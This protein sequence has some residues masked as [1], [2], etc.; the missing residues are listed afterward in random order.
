[1]HAREGEARVESALFVARAEGAES[2]R[3]E[4]GEGG[5]GLFA[6]VEF[7]GESEDFNAWVSSPDKE[8]VVAEVGITGF[9][10]GER[11]RGFA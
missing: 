5:E 6:G 2:E 1:V 8:R 11:C 10:E 4:A 9:H 7:A 3:G